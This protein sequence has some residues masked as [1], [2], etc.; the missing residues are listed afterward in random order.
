MTFLELIM[1]NIDVILI[2]CKSRNYPFYTYLAEHLPG[3]SFIKVTN[4]NPYVLVLKKIMYQL[5]DLLLH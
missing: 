1:E 5:S 3:C 2:R 4:Y